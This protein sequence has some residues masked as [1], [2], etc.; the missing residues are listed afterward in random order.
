MKFLL[1]HPHSLDTIIALERKKIVMKFFLIHYAKNSL[2]QFHF[3]QV[4]LNVCSQGLRW[5][6]LM[7]KY[8]FHQNTSRIILLYNM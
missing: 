3:K 5:L 1:Y 4:T 2:Y 8:C 6:V 7:H